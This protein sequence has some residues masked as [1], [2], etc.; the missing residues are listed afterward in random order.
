MTDNEKLTNYE[1]LKHIKNVSRC[2]NHIISHL[3]LRSKL[4]D[5]SKLENPEL[6]VFTEFTPKL[7]N[8]TYGSEEYKGFL[9]AMGP[10]LTHHY[11]ENRHH[12]EHFDNGIDDMNLIDLI[13]M[14]CDWKAATLRHKDGCLRQ[15]IEINKKRFGISNQLAQIFENSRYIVE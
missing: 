2:I 15:S 4:H 5:D 12:P 9:K 7:A 14:F 1:T 3:L 10:A 6:A 8:S 13:E 11:E